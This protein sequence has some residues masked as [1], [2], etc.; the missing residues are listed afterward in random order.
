MGT[1]SEELELP[2]WSAGL[3]AETF[4]CFT[5]KKPLAQVRRG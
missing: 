1:E 2:D 5:V 4:D 3:A